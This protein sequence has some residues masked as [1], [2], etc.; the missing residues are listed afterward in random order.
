MEESMAFW[1]GFADGIKEINPNSYIIAEMT[2][3]GGLMKQSGDITG[4][5]K[6]DMALESAFV[7]ATGVSGLSN[8]NYTYSTPLSIVANIKSDEPGAGDTNVEGL[9]NK[10]IGNQPGWHGNEGLFFGYPQDQVKTSHN[11]FANHDKPRMLSI[12]ALDNN[13]FHGGDKSEGYVKEYTPNYFTEG[14]TPRYKALAMAKAIDHNLGAEAYNMGIAED[15][16]TALKIA[17][18]DLAEGSFLGSKFDPE[19]FG[20]APIEVAISDVFKQ[21]KY[22]R[23]EGAVSPNKEKA[24]KEGKFVKYTLAEDKENDLSDKTFEAILKPALDKMLMMDE[25]LSVM[26]GRSTT[27]AGDEY[28]ATGYETPSKNIYAQNRNVAHR[29]WAKGENG[30]RKQFIEEYYDKKQAINERRK[31][32]KTDKALS[33]LSNGET[34]MLSTNNANVMAMFR[35]NKLSELIC[36]VHS[37]EAGSLDKLTLDQEEKYKDGA[38]VAGLAG[39]LA[40]GTYFKDIKEKGSAIFGV[41]EEYGKKTLRKFSSTKEYKNYKPGQSANFIEK[42][43]L[44]KGVVATILKKGG[45]IRFGNS[46]QN[47]NHIKIQ[48]YLNSKQ[49]LNTNNRQKA[50]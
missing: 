34:V 14:K 25:I 44:P 20:V 49:Y 10:L 12:L 50:I 23:Q 15:Q 42:F 36:L 16:K 33:P 19:A 11:F 13:L 37:P 45:D 21:A 43:E 39:G 26:P 28:G 8:Y 22:L 41:C 7:V 3:I 1:K 35:Y 46:I 27:Y 40:V 2:D 47:Q 6:N 48:A 30:E 18:R 31:Y 17:L 5:Y 4:K 9:K 38:V 32:N 29:E 24:I